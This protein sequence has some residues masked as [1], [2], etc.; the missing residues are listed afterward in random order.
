VTV[1]VDRAGLL[2]L[3][4]VAAA[5]A[6]IPAAAAADAARR[7]PQ[8]HPS[9]RFVFV[10]HALTNPFFVPAKYGSADA[11]NLLGVRVDWTGSV[12]SNIGEMVQAME[13]AIDEEVDGIA[14]SLI[15]PTAFNGP[16]V[17]ALRQGIPVVS[18]NADGGRGNARLAYIGQDNYQS[19]LELGARIVSLVA[20]GEVFLFIA[21]PGQENIQPRV[22]G[23]LDALRDSGKQIDVQVV[24][25]G[26]DVAGEKTKVAETYRMN[27][28]LRGLFAVDAGSTAGVAAVMGEH[29]LHAR[30]V[31]AGGY[32]LLPETLRAINDRDLDFAIDQQ[33]YLQGFLPVL[34]LFLYRY[35]GR[36]IAPADTNTGVNFVTRANVAQYLM[37]SSRYEGSSSREA[38]P[39]GLK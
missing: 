23:A 16:T 39:V 14:V 34:D 2:R 17:R 13:R 11:A 38:Y 20:G 24:A 7:F 12:S 1:G 8:P 21:T 9:W 31:R 18:Y 36:L 10:N 26:V 33:P 32:D 28:T 22:D 29:A 5:G 27:P 15:D 6:T 4:V 30:G 3:G 25:S 35:S 19:G 37:T